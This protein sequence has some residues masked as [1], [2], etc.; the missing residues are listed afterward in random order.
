MSTTFQ[1]EGRITKIGDVQA[2]GTNGFRKREFIRTLRPTG[3]DDH[4]I[5]GHDIL[6]EFRFIGSTLFIF[7]LHLHGM[8]FIFC[9]ISPDYATTADFSFTCSLI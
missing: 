8:C 1:L 9:P 2:I 6:P 7:N 4:P 5:S 3:G